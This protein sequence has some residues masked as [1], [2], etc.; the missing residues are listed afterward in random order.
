MFTSVSIRNFRCFD[1]LSIESMGRVNLIAGANNLGKTALLEAIFLL[2]GAMNIGLVIKISAFRGISEFKGNLSSIRESLWNPLFLNFDTRAK[3]EING[4]LSSGG[5]H[6][7]KLHLVQGSSA[8]L[9]IGDKS[10]SKNELGTTGLPGQVLQLRFEDSSGKTQSAEMIVDEKGLRVEPAPPEPP[11]PGYF[12][13]ACHRLT[14]QEDAERFGR[15]EVIEEPYNLLETLQII[16]PRLKRIAT[17]YSAGVPMLYGN[18]GLA[19]MLPLPLM[20]DGL[21]RLISILLAIANAPHGVVLIDEIENGLHHSVMSKVWQAIDHAA[22][23]FDTQVFA[24]THSLECIRAAGEAFM[25]SERN[26]FRLHRLE[27][28]DD[29]IRAVTYDE[30]TLASAMRAD[31]EVR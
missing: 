26:D 5:R 12:L 24:A 27:R 8:H 19:R 29:R 21:G 11:F 2:L 6:S 15:L 1:E 13:A 23:R 17:I 10:N 25:Q 16:E 14:P 31:L 22:L 20:G 28:V 30:E 4:S 9:A 3:I 18:L 7:I